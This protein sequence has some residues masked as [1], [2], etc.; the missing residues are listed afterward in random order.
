MIF[1]LWK[2]LSLWAPLLVGV[3]HQ[4]PPLTTTRP[5]TKFSSTKSW[6]AF[7]KIFKACYLTSGKLLQ[8]GLSL[9]NL[10]GH[11]VITAVNV[12]DVFISSR[13]WR[14][15]HVYQVFSYMWLSISVFSSWTKVKKE[16]N[17]YTY[18]CTQS[19]TCFS[20]SVVLPHL[21]LVLPGHRGGGGQLWGGH[22]NLFKSL[23][24]TCRAPPSTSRTPTLSCLGSP[25][26]PSSPSWASC[27]S[28]PSSTSSSSS[29][30]SSAAPWS[31]SGWKKSPNQTLRK[32][33][34]CRWWG[35]AIWSTE[36]VERR[37]RG[38]RCWRRGRACWTCKL[39][40]EQGLMSEPWQF[41]LL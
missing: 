35:R 36:K 15:L 5:P 32:S 2:S 33:N 23:T 1:L 3:A 24:S 25:L 14:C 7:Q 8:H 17:E 39:N 27:S 9:E 21:L 37:A 41:L 26:T 6:A 40:T 30:T 38:W 29:S 20:D 18:I 28:S 34:L 22:R 19:K 31:R 16:K 12:I 4:N 11:A 10:V 13:P